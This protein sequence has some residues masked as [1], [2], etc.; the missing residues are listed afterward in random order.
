MFNQFEHETDT[1]HEFLVKKGDLNSDE[2]WREANEVWRLLAN[3]PTK[4]E[5]LGP[6]GRLLD[7]HDEDI[8]ISEDARAFFEKLY[9][10]IV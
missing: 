2:A 8:E 7:D 6:L 1:I 3:I 9:Q 5:I 4:E 10:Q